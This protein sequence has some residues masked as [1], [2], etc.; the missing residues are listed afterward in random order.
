MSRLAEVHHRTLV[1]LPSKN[2]QFLGLLQHEQINNKIQLAQ[3]TNGAMYNLGQ[4]RI[5]ALG[6]GSKEGDELE[7]GEIWGQ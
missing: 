4:F 3:F 6:M 2:L 5:S 1:F 7:Q